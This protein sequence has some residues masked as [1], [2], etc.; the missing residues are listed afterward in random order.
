MGEQGPKQRFSTHT[1]DWTH[2]SPGAVRWNRVEKY[3]LLNGWSFAANWKKKSTVEIE[4]KGKSEAHFV[5]NFDWT[6][7]QFTIR[8]EKQIKY[9][10]TYYN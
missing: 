3:L 6:W 7:W 4:R 2:D 8:L 9:M 10:L 5:Y 1:Y